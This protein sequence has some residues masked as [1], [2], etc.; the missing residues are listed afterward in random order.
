MAL[1]KLIYETLFGWS[2]ARQEGDDAYYAGLS[3]DFNPYQP[4][5]AQHEEWRRG[6]FRN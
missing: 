1:L 3:E 6:F 4:G 5:T 2:Q